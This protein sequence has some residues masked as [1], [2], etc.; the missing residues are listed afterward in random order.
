MSVQEEDATC[1]VNETASL[2][3][4]WNHS[5]IV[6]ASDRTFAWVYTKSFGPI[7]KKKTLVLDLLKVFE[8][9]ISALNLE[10]ISRKLEALDETCSIFCFWAT[11]GQARVRYTICVYRHRGPEF[12]ILIFCM[13]VIVARTVAVCNR[14]IIIE[15]RQK[16]RM[17]QVLHSDCTC[18]KIPSLY[19]LDSVYQNVN[20]S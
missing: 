20:V 8:I 5:N 3:I 19:V 17:W 15:S 16:I 18:R 9:L 7:C 12:H 11:L 10:H 14:N 1:D 4:S 13:Y 6:R 2:Q